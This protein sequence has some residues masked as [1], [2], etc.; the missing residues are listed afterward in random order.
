MSRSGAALLVGVEEVVDGGV[1]LV[2]RLLDEAQ[3]EHPRVE[4]EVPRRVAGDAGDVVDAVQFH[5]RS[6]LRGSMRAA[7]STRG[8]CPAEAA[9]RA[10]S[11]RSVKVGIVVPFS[12]SF[13]GAVVEHAE[14]QAAALEE[15]GHDVRLL[16]A[17]DPP[18]QFTR[19]LHPRVGRHGHPPATVIPVGTL[20]D[21]PRERVAAEHLPQPALGLPR[22]RG[23]RARALRRPAPPRADDADDLR[24]H[25]RGRDLPDRGD[26]P[27]LRRPR[28]DAA[29]MPI[30]GFLLSGST[31]GSRSPSRHGPRSSGGC[32]AT[33]R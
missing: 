32:P 33:A 19:A 25:A 26:A 31:A 4:V 29:R 7:G 27:R 5:S 17:N 20:G 11:L 16:M 14:L 10:R 12:W 15:R 30:W 8:W 28:L 23:A 6:F 22:P 13:W 24:R 18:G 21:R 1:V 2:D 9:S 3:P